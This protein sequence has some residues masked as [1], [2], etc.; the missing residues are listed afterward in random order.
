MKSLHRAARAAAVATFCVITMS[1]VAQAPSRAGGLGDG[2]MITAKRLPGNP[3]VTPESDPSIGTNINGPSL[4]KVPSW[5]VKPLG[6]YYLYFADHRGTY[7]RL[8][9]SNSL[10][11]PNPLRGPKPSENSAPHE[12]GTNAR[13]SVGL[14]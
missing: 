9:Y 6:K 3:I 11:G 10:S 4:I 8:A 2:A 13:D 12:P 1:M 14:L 5:V 7:I